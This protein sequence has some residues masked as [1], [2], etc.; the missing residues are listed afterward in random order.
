M[1]AAQHPGHWR[2]QALVQVLRLLLYS[3]G[4][5]ASVYLAATPVM[6]LVR[7]SEQGLLRAQVMLWESGPGSL[8]PTTSDVTEPQGFHV[9]TSTGHLLLPQTN[10]GPWNFGQFWDFMV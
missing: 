8:E 3:E 6:G 2:L 4:A 9:Q 10:T 7:G 5:L 1:G